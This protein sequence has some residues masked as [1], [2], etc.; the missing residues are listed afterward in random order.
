M[1]FPPDSAPI[2]ADP[3]E[4]VG[5]Q[6]HHLL[7]RRPVRQHASRGYREA[8]QKYRKMS[9]AVLEGEAIPLGQRQ[10]IRKYFELIRPQNGDLPDK[11]A[12]GAKE[13][14][15]GAGAK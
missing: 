11:P 12:D 1:Q 8:Y 3:T 6:F 13:P 2:I 4:E 9:E 7:G 5:A 15:K 14:A 10:M